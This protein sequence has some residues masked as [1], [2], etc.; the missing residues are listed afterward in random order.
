VSY[1]TI[2]IGLGG[3][4]SAALFHLAR[5]GA[6][7]LGLEQFGIA[8]ELGSSHG[9]SRIIRLAYAE[10]PDYVPLLRRAYAS[11]RALEAQAGERLLVNTGGIDA[12]L[13]DSTIVRGALA[14]CAVHDLPHEVLEAAALARRFPGY[15]LRRNMMAV[16]QPDAGFLAPERCVAAHVSAAHAYDAQVHTEEKVI[17]WA[18][19]GAEVTVTTSRSTYRARALVV[20][21]GPWARQLV[22]ALD[23]L[24]VPERQVMLWTQ[25]IEPAL[26]EVGRFPVFNMEAPEGR[27]YGFPLDNDAAFKI[28][29]YHHRCERVDDPDS[30]DRDCHDEDEAALREGLR[31]YFPAADGPAVGMKTCLFTNSPDEH[32]IVDR[33]PDAPQ[34]A[35]AAGC[36]GHGFKFCSVIGEILA[37][38]AL[39]GGTNYGIGLFRL[40]RF[41]PKHSAARERNI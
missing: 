3:M 4:G 23:R 17:S 2:V 38:L 7:V 21:A 35:I 9:R 14:S 26:F 31:R 32:F 1:D 36:S 34:V 22:P 41:P 15:R 27:F 37:D 6:R 28:G 29:K 16:F 10:H 19:D 12:G 33:L 18:T 5:R 39:D 40:D 8:H 30:M 13:E 20:T 25:P 24:A 11:W